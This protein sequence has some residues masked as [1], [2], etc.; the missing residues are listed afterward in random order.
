[1]PGTGSALPSPPRSANYAVVSCS[2]KPTKLLSCMLEKPLPTLQLGQTKT[3]SLCEKAPSIILLPFPNAS[4]PQAGYV[5]CRKIKRCREEQAP[6]R[7]CCL[8][9]RTCWAGTGGIRSRG[10]KRG[11]VGKHGSGAAAALPGCSES[12]ASPAL[13]ISSGYQMPPS[14]PA[15]A[16]GAQ[17]PLIAGSAAVTHGALCRR[18]GHLLCPPGSPAQRRPF[19][20]QTPH[21]CSRLWSRPETKSQLNP[22]VPPIPPAGAP[23]WLR[24]NQQLRDTPRD[25]KTS[26]KGGNAGHS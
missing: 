18:A 12:A 9:R 1:M 15:P 21:G 25:T 10:G 20:A 16:H 13:R 23:R 26:T 19:P 5:K 22:L 7:C 8:T 2:E 11:G 14:G 24:S 17:A 3:T 6:V 4:H